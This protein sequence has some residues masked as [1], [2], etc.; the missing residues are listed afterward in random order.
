MANFHDKNAKFREKTHCRLL[1][2]PPYKHC[3]HKMFYHGENCYLANFTWRD[4]THLAG[5]EGEGA[6]TGAE[7]LHHHGDEMV[8]AGLLEVGL[9]ADERALLLWGHVDCEV[10]VSL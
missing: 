2:L 8:V 4:H 3:T 1:I 10:R 7:Q 6:A 5:K 9:E